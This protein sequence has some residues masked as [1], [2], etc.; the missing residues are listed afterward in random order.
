M[1]LGTA[2]TGI[3]F[4]LLAS[5]ILSRML[6][7]GYAGW[8]GLVG[9]LM[10]MAFGYPAGVF[11]GIILFKK[12]LHYSGSILLGLAGVIIGGI[13]PFV[14]AEPL[15]FNLNPDLLWATILLG[16]PIMG[17]AGFYLKRNSGKS[18]G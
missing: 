12:L 5:L 3:L 15:S 8:G 6:E 11:I 13:L 18:S 17:T 16:S 10:G 7:G 1:V 4:G 9:A 14:L 2:V